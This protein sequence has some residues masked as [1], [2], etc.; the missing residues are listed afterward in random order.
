MLTSDY[1]RLSA[2]K[3]LGGSNIVKS[4]ATSPYGSNFF[5]PYWK[6]RE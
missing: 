4:S 5:G 3:F 2:A 6:E 1:L